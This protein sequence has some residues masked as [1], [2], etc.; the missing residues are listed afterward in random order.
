MNTLSIK[1]PLTPGDKF[2]ISDLIQ[3]FANMSLSETDKILESVKDLSPEDHIC[4]EKVFHLPTTTHKID[5]S[6]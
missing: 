6:S 5:L 3:A 2:L 4:R 1:E